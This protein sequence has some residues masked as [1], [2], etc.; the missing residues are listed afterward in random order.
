MDCKAETVGRHAQTVG[1][2]IDQIRELLGLLKERFLCLGATVSRVDVSSDHIKSLQAT[3][4]NVLE[5]DDVPAELGANRLADFARLEFERR[6]FKF[7][8]HRTA[9]KKTGCATF[10]L[11]AHVVR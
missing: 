4:L 7:R 10:G 1:V 3:G 9:T 8:R 5:F 2:L 11:G 6:F